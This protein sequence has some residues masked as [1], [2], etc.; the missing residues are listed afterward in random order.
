MKIV[1]FQR[2]MA[3]EV[4]RCY[5]ELVAP[6]PFCLPIGEEWF[7]D[8]GRLARGPCRNETLLVAKE[9][10]GEIAGFVHVAV[11]APATEDWHVKGE[12]GLIRF[13]S[14]PVGRRAVGN[15]LLEAAE[16][17]LRERGRSE[18]VA[19][20]ARY[21][22]PC[23][24]LPFAHLSERIAHV[25]PLLGMGGYAVAESEVLFA[26]EDFGV[27]DV[28]KPGLDVELAAEWRDQVD[29][30]GEGVVV[31]PR[32]GSKVLGEC[33]IV[34]LGSDDWRPELKGWCFCTSLQVEGAVQGMGLGRHL[35]AVGLRRM[36]EVGL[37]HALISTD[38]DNHRAAL[39]YTNFGYRF[40][41]RT[42][43]FRKEL[44]GAA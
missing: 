9:S 28:P 2:E 33:K 40:L 44:T 7:R 3:G 15:A 36:R 17:W 29:T 6:A 19:L 21:L 31:E 42:S 25:P 18:V 22:Y 14:Y 5:S 24:H 27:S 11:A 35:L 10:S 23:Y 8:P 30:F 16:A 38:W 13:L 41:D 26:W 4:A 20:D 12:P 1:G 43:A 37:R 39:F 34:R 32:R